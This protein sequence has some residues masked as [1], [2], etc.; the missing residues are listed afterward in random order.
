MKLYRGPPMSLGNAAGAKVRWIVWRRDCRLQVEPN[1]GEMA[2]RYGA[3]TTVSESLER[4]VFCF[5]WRTV[6]L[7]APA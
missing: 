2:E 3:E 6:V 1:P 4:F 7:N 5:G